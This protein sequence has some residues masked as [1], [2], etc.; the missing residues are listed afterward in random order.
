MNYRQ[1]YWKK[2]KAQFEITWLILWHGVIRNEGH[3]SKW[4][5]GWFYGKKK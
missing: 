5:K 3:H 4:G 1:Y 2:F